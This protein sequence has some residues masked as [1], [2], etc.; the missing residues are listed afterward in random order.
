MH[1]LRRRTRAVQGLCS[2]A[3]QHF[4]EMNFSAY[5]KIQQKPNDFRSITL[6]LSTVCLVAALSGFQVSCAMAEESCHGEPAAMRAEPQG[7]PPPGPGE[8]LREPGLCA[9]QGYGHAGRSRGHQENQAD[10]ESF[11][12]LLGKKEF[13]CLSAC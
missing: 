4:P 2:F 11:L 7:R 6:N 8:E 1:A 9:E 13:R 12:V 3:V 10:Q 5:S